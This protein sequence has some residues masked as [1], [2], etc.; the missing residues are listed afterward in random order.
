MTSLHKTES[1]DFSYART[2]SKA[3]R[4]VDGT[5]LSFTEDQGNPDSIAAPIPARL[6]ASSA[7]DWILIS[8][9]IIIIN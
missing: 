6:V 5:S 9:T 1:Q 4:A 7:R 3:P 8:F 2:K